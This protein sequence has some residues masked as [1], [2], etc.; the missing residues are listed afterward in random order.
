MKNFQIINNQKY[1]KKDILGLQRHDQR[2][3]KESKNKDI[4]KTKSHLNYYI[5]GS[6]KNYNEIIRE[7]I[8]SCDKKPKSD[9]VLMCQMLITF[10]PEQKNILSEEEKKRYFEDSVCFLKKQFGE[11]NFISACVHLDE[12]TPHMHFNY[13]PII[14]KNNQ[15]IFCAK[16][17]VNRDK[18]RKLHTDFNI[19]VGSKYGLERG[20]SNLDTGKRVYHEDIHTFKAKNN[21]MQ[22]Q[23]E[24]EKLALEQER[25]ELDKRKEQL[26]HEKNHIDKQEKLALEQGKLEITRQKEELEKEKLAL[27]KEKKQILEKKEII[28]KQNEMFTQIKEN[29][30]KALQDSIE[31]KER[32]NTR[33]IQIKAEDVEPKVLEKKTL[34]KDVIENSEQIAERLNNGIISKYINHLKSIKQSNFNLLRSDENRRLINLEER[35]KELEPLYNLNSSDKANVLEFAESLQ[36]SKALQADRQREKTNSQTQ[37]L[38]R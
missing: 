8:K 1:K 11:E 14:S 22:K 23:L 21:Q 36:Q 18:L 33:F 27:D 4:D 30:N 28:N 26:E 5:A 12:E 34:G 32:D 24:Q 10:S 2:Y 15:K 13:T 6:F 7:R 16:D 9:A 31:F 25:L 35:Y 29:N 38:S 37:A 3:G 20:K 17:L 19:E